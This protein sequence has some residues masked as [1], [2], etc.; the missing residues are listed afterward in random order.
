MVYRS[1]L[2]RS[3]LKLLLITAAIALISPLRVSALNAES[4]E[5]SAEVD[6]LCAVRFTLKKPPGVFTVTFRGNN[7]PLNRVS[8]DSDISESGVYLVGGVLLLMAEPDFNRAT[9]ALTQLENDV[10]TTLPLKYDADLLSKQLNECIE[11]TE[12][13]VIPKHDPDSANA[14]IP[15]PAELRQQAEMLNISLSDFYTCPCGEAFSTVS[16]QSPPWHYNKLVLHRDKNACTLSTDEPNNAESMSVFRLSD[17]NKTEQQMD[18]MVQIGIRTPHDQTNF[19]LKNKPAYNERAALACNNI[20]AAKAQAWF[21]AGGKI[22]ISDAL[23][24]AEK[25]I[26][27]IPTSFS[28]LSCTAH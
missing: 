23:I 25:P 19:K 28:E 15:T 10:Q 20:I 18:C 4:I 9:L 27:S 22:S 11:T 5:A 6:E 8:P 13:T 7:F 21:K 16:M 17:A 2:S 1:L 26:L 3:A 24:D 14:P 12:N